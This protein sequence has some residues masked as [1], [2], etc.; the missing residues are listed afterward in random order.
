MPLEHWDDQR[1]KWILYKSEAA[2]SADCAKF[3]YEKIPLR[4]FFDTNVLN[5]IIKFREQVFDHAAMPSDAHETTLNDIEAL[6]HVFQVGARA[7]WQI[8][9]SHKALSEIEGV[10]DP[11]LRRDLIDYGLELVDP[12][13]ENR[14]H[15]A[16]LGRRLADAPILSMLKDKADRELIGNAIGYGCDAFCTCDRRTITKKR[17]QLPRLPLR[18]VTPVEWWAHLKPWGGLWL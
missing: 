17:E 8:L 15:A 10:R 5:L 4:V 11:D 1:K 3:P 9:T 6:M 14:A 13:D 2:H 16:S 18:I 7:S 12:L